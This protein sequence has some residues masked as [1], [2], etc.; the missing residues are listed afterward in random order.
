M[1]IGYGLGM[2]LIGLIAIT[3]GGTIIFKVINKL[4][5]K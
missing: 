4:E 3:I 2:L 1:T 5:D